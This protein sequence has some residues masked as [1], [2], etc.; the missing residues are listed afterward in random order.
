MKK[1]I[2]NIIFIVIVVFCFFMLEIL[3]RVLKV[4]YSTEPFVLHPQ[5]RQFYI[6]NKELRLKY[7]PRKIDLSRDPIKNIFMAHKPEGLLRGFV[8]GGS[9]AEGFPFYSNH[10]FS[11]ILEA[12]LS[13]SGKFKKVEVIN[14]GFSAMSS[15]Y[16][17]D[18]SKKLL[19]YKPDFV[20]IYSGHNEYYGTISATTGGGHLTKKIYLALK[21]L[22]FFQL[23][24]EILG[25][26]Q[27]KGIY[28]RTM[29][30]EQFNNRVLPFNEKL[31]NYVA[32]CYIKNIDEVIKEFT[33]KGIHVIWVEPVCNL[34]DMPPF[35]GKNDNKL[36]NYIV[37]YYN[38]IILKKK[39]DVE[40]IEKELKGLSGVSENAN[41]IY[42]NALK[43]YYFGHNAKLDGF[44]EAKDKDLVPFRV[45]TPIV[46]A[47][48][49]YMN[50]HKNQYLHYIPLQSR[51]EKN[52]GS[53]GFGNNIFIDHLHFN[54]KGH[55]LMAGII[56]Q[57]IAN[58][59]GFGKNER[60]KVI[61]F[62]M[63]EN[64]IREK[65]YFTPLNDFVAYRSI[66][67][68]SKQIPY[69]DMLIKFVPSP[70]LRNPFLTN[71]DAYILSEEELFNKVL[72]EFIEKKDFKK[73]LFYLNSVLA[74]YPGEARNYLAMADLQSML[75]QEEAFYNYVLAYVLS[76]RKYEYYKKLEDYLIS[77]HQDV[78]L[79][80]IISMYGKPVK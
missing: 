15:Y 1:L 10:S 76:G 69:S 24:F 22:R 75:N 80:K 28:S 74:I 20:V 33:S 55:I 17:A 52:F 9:A 70:D 58:I 8:I 19:K 13:E 38:A 40:K 39:G 27:W 72:N 77:R 61:E 4:G 56:A 46:E 79:N 71:K 3:L 54:F 68:L 67:L 41:F 26:S 14:L 78:M 2:F 25:R 49:N 60:K 51:I 42:L 62:L 50:S 48:K 11:K 63:D 6:D 47:I 16:V 30:A 31:D 64:R 43:D 66:L 44:I 12:A 53:G 7:Y 65:I 23:I 34:I 29:M 45:R 21:E 35:K 37:P 57:E 18:V 59:Y 73:A 5:L 32:K 36:S